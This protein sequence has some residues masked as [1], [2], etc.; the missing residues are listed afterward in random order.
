MNYQ[1][2]ADEEKLKEFIDWLPDLQDNETYYVSLL[3][4]KKYTD[5]TVKTNDKT[6]L[7][8]FTAS[9]E[10]LIEKIRQLEIAEGNWQLKQQPAPQNALALYITLNPRCMKKATELMGKR[11]WDLIKANNYNL[12]AEAMSCIQKS[13]ARTCYIDFDIDDKSVDMDQDWLRKNIGAENYTIIETRGGYHLLIEPE[14]ATNFRKQNFNDK[15]W[16]QIVQKKY[17]VDQSGDQL[18]PVPGTFQG[19]FVPRFLEGDKY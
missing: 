5:G 12:Q 11:C 16:F 4:R 19:G 9:K 6:Q 17:P 7:K 18:L 15:D 2:I 8:R 10:R 1:I 13:K 14:K 3:A